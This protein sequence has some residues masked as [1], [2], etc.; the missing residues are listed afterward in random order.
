MTGKKTPQGSEQRE[1]CSR[2]G[3][4]YGEASAGAHLLGG[5]RR[6]KRDPRVVSC[7]DAGMAVSG[8]LV[9]WRW[10]SEGDGDI[11][12]GV[13]FSKEVEGE[14]GFVCVWGVRS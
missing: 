13:A 9:G 10:A 4:I 1:T 7:R 5:R 12:V 2:D 6:A 8:L 11:Q 3:K 14:G